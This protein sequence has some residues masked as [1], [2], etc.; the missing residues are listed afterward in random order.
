MTRLHLAEEED[1]GDGDQGLDR[2]DADNSE[3]RHPGED[4]RI[5]IGTGQNEEDQH[6]GSDAALALTGA[7]LAA[8]WAQDRDIADP[9]TLAALLQACG[10]PA[11]RLAQSQT[12]AV[13]AAC[14]AHTQAAIDGGVFGAPS[15][16]LDGEIFWGQDRLD[17]LQHQLG[18]K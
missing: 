17:F 12:P 7:V 9:T 5:G 15:Y 13:A 4:H 16:V 6:D 1:D 11:E 2:E 3:C 8:C 14:Q 18:A 10:L